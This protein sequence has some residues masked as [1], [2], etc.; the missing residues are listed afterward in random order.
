MFSLLILSRMGRTNGITLNTLAVAACL[1]LLWNPFYLFEV[2]FQLSFVAVASII[3]FQPFLY[4]QIKVRNRIGRYVWGVTTV[5]IAAQIGTCPIVMFY[6]SAF[7]VYF[8]LA[9][10]FAIPWVFVI[11]YA[12]VLMLFSGFVPFIQLYIADIVE[13]MIKALNEWT[14]FISNLPCSSI[15]HLWITPVDMIIF[16]LVIVLLALYVVRKYRRAVVYAGVSVLLLCLHHTTRQLSNRE[17]SCIIFYDNRSCPAVHFVESRKSSYL[18]SL[19]D[20]EATKRMQHSYQRYWDSRQMNYP[21]LL[22]ANKNIRGIWENNNIVHF[23]GRTVCVLTDNRWRNKTANEPLYVDYMY[24]CKGFKGKLAVLAPLF[25]ARKI[26]LDSS[27][28]TYRLT[29]LKDECRLL[30]LDFISIS[31]KGSLHIDL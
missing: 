13:W 10:L 9:N 7:P 12:T 8:L 15:E 25:E 4:N 14:A 20:E 21:G 30:G 16:Y 22:T 6:F 18:L 29:E 23:R 5:T 28:S 19:G 17:G 27:L 31:E 2:S 3:I 11:M 24:V 1:M 26:I